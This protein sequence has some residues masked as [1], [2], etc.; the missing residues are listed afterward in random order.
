MTHATTSHK[1]SRI[2][3]LL[4]L[5][6]TGGVLLFFV[7]CDAGRVTIEGA[8]SFDGH[9]IE[10]GSI[11]F[12]PAD[13]KGA[14]TGAT[15]ADGRYSLNNQEGIAAAKKVVRITGVRKTG[16]K[17]EAG[18]PSPPGTL[19]DEVERYI[20]AIYNKKSTLTC[21]IAAGANELNFDLEPQ[22]E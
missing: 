21:E 14:S 4:A 19:V 22:T 1:P 8:V 10:S 18:P 20:P 17:I 13:G 5:A 2:S 15:I 9:P 3:L 12:E 6:A 11:V 16:R 7:G